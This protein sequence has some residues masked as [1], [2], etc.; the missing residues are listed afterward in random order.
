MQKTTAKDFFFYLASFAALYVSAIS[1]VSLLFAIVNKVF[2]DAL[3]TYYYYS[4]DPYSGGMRLAIASLVIVFPLY[5]IVAT[6]LNRYLRANP[7]KKDIAVRK[8]LTYLTLFV[9]GIAVVSDLVVLVNTFLGGE[10]TTRF[11]FKVLSVLIVAGAIF[12]YYLYDL[13]KS[14]VPEM[15]NRSKMIVGLACVLV[16]GT[17]ISGFVLLGSPM[18]ARALRFDDRRA[19]DLSSIQSYLTYSYWQQKGSLPTA[20]ADLRDPISGFMVPNDPE[21]GK[22]YTYEK[23]GVMSFKLC[24]YFTLESRGM[25]N[26]KE[27]SSIYPME[28]ANWTHDAG[29]QCFERTID[30]ELYPVRAKGI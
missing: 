19:N 15:P 3:N 29:T 8:W 22:P 12:W 1:L 28:S 13:R 23:T 11:V 25:I 14:F 5:L 21:T 20:L 18:T 4:S 9:T 27:Y 16:F 6:Y 17:L 30:P 24:A 10:I 7:D 2:P 26:G